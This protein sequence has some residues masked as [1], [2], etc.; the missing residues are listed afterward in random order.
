M[1]GQAVRLEDEAN[2]LIDERDGRRAVRRRVRRRRHDGRRA[3]ARPVP[4]GAGPADIEE[5]D[6]AIARLKTG[7]YGYSPSLAGQS[8]ESAWKRSR[9]RR[10][11]R[12]EGRRDRQAMMA[13]R[14]R[15]R[16]ED[17]DVDSIDIRPTQPDRPRRYSL[18]QRRPSPLCGQIV[19]QRCCDPGHQALGPPSPPTADRVMCMWTLQWNLTRNSGMAF[20]QARAS[21]RTSASPL[22]WW[23]CVLVSCSRGGEPGVDDRGRPR[24]SAA[25]SATSATACS[26]TTDGCTARGRLHRLAMVPDLQR[27]RHG[28]RHRGSAVPAVDRLR[29]TPGSLGVIREEIPPRSRVNDSTGWSP[30]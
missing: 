2:S 17:D 6:A 19:A 11:H 13:M 21:G 7:H 3:R 20:S 27:R 26:A 8:R 18:H 28:G 16:L 5:I 29:A 12:G 14:R 25:R 1:T 24:W 23:S 30:W 10:A 9:G 4:V 15:R 22:C